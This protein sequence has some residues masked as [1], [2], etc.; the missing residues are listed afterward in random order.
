MQQLITKMQKSVT[1]LQ[2]ELLN[3]QETEANRRFQELSRMM[4]TFG[5]EGMTI[6]NRISG[7]RDP[8]VARMHQMFEA[9]FPDII[10]NITDFIGN[11]LPTIGQQF[12][13][14]FG[15]PPGNPPT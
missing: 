7:R 5:G 2:K 11:A 14:I 3:D 6:L 4:I 15:Q 9:G 1:E 13:G 8:E 10:G 12:G